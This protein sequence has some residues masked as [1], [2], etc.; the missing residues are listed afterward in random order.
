MPPTQYCSPGADRMTQYTPQCH[1]QH[2]HRGSKA[3]CCYLHQC[4]CFSAAAQGLRTNQTYTP[5]WAGRNHYVHLQ[6]TCIVS[7][8]LRCHTCDDTMGRMHNT[9]G[10]GTKKHILLGSTFCLK[11]LLSPGN[12]QA[13]RRRSRSQSRE[14]C[15]RY[16]QCTWHVDWRRQSGLQVKWGGGGWHMMHDIIVL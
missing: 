6:P 5:K 16:E 13:C 10:R 14:Y 8:P 4:M 9:A 11:A 1:P 12:R 3:Y 7:M 2:I 15:K